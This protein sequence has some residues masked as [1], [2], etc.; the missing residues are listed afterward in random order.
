[1]SQFWVTDYGAILSDD[2]GLKCMFH[3]EGVV[4]KQS[5]H[6][7]YTVPFNPKELIGECSDGSAGTFMIELSSTVCSH[8]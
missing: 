1:M 7:K 4:K 2:N 3:L 5:T 6:T 8:F